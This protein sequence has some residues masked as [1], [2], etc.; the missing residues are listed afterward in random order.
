LVR[1]PRDL[2]IDISIGTICVY[3]WIIITFLSLF[4]YT[5]YKVFLYKDKE[6]TIDYLRYIRPLLTF[7]NDSLV[8]LDNY[9]KSLFEKQ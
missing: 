6:K 3:V 4:V 7:W 9:I 5:V 8:N 2:Y 1:L